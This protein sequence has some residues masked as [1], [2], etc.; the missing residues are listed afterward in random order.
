MTPAQRNAKKAM[1]LHHEDGYS[2]KE[3]W[4]M[5]KGSKS[6]P[7]KRNPRKR[8]GY[9]FSFTPKESDWWTQAKLKV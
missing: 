5:V 7:R 6:N 8:K 2:L 1:K 3:A 4:R 9:K